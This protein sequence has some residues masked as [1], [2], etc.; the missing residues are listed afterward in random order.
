MPVLARWSPRECVAEGIQTQSEAQGMGKGRC[1]RQ[2]RMYFRVSSN[3][4][5]P[6]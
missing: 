4:K 3:P 2:N 1:V 6:Y 5:I